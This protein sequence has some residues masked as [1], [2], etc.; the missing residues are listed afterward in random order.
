MTD[1]QYILIVDD[2]AATR[3]TIRDIVEIDNVVGHMAKNVAEAFE[4]LA[5]TD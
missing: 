3:E 2:H 4:K 1:K 5:Q